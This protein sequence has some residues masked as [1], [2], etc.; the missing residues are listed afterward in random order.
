MFQLFPRIA[1]L[2]KAKNSRIVPH[3]AALCRIVPVLNT[4]KEPF[5]ALQTLRLSIL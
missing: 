1:S 3:C 5:H 4:Y 2:L